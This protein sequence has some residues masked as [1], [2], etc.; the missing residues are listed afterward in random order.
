MKGPWPWV[1]MDGLGAHVGG[2]W[3][4]P[5]AKLE[6]RHEVPRMAPGFLEGAPGG[7]E[8]PLTKVGNPEGAAGLSRGWWGKESG[9]LLWTH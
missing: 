4:G 7:L 8:G 5:G 2:R 6:S 9:V 3:S 1:Q